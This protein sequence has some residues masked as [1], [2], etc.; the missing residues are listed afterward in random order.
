MWQKPDG[1]GTLS[2]NARECSLVGTTRH[3]S[4]TG[5]FLSQTLSVRGH[6]WC[7]TRVF[8][9]KRENVITSWILSQGPFPWSPPTTMIQ[10][11]ASSGNFLY[12]LRVRVIAY[13][14]EPDKLVLL[15]AMITRMQGTKPARCSEWMELESLGAPDEHSYFNKFFKEVDKYDKNSR[16]LCSIPGIWNG[17]RKKHRESWRF[18]AACLKGL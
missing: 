12:A 9:R 4:T 8:T 10:V 2:G 5:A 11:S 13:D 6:S 15:R 1:C 7:S 14:A 17:L 18:N 16:N 3:T